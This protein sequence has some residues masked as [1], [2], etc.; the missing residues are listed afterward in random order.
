M[1]WQEFIKDYLN[2]SRK[3]RIAVI[4]IAC[5]ILLVFLLPDFIKGFS[6][7]SNSGMDTAWFSA[8]RK[9]QLKSPDTLDRNYQNENEDRYV[10]NYQYDKTKSSYDDIKN[11]TGNLFYFDPNTID[12]NEWK[13]LGLREKTIQ[14]I[15]N[16]LTKGGKFRKPE[17]LKKV[18]GLKEKEY[19]RLV[20]YIKIEN[21]TETK[22]FETYTK[23][24]Y[25]TLPVKSFTSVYSIID[26]NKSDTTAFISLP[27]IG[28]KLA[29]RIV[30]FR[31]KLGG[32]YSIEQVK[33]T[34]GL[35][36]STYQK[37][38]QYLKLDNPLV[39]KININTATIDELKTHPYIK[40]SLANPI[41]AYR[42]E[43]GL[44]S[45]VEDVKKVMAV[46]DDIFNKISPYLVTQ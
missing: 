4:I 10:Y 16:Y 17:D 45:K 9:L 1:K 19:D 36:D 42:N 5:M 27:G 11:T 6:L 37:I 3:E 38:K 28:S 12:E 44:F 23:K 24:E 41:V 2:F 43:H 7:T 40:Y 20:P 46:T 18:Y 26:V 8:V 15:Q 33:E 22:E 14:T 32:F 39:K 34:F 25:E 35:P 29:A 31:D 13:K 30:N 21:A